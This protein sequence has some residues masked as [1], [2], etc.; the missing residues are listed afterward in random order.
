MVEKNK[1]EPTRCS[2]LFSYTSE[3][4]QIKS[5]SVCNQASQV[6]LA[7]FDSEAPLFLHHCQVRVLQVERLPTD[8]VDSAA[9]MI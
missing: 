1:R 4:Q 6:T 7:Q 2:G 3:L 9:T 8:S 5:L